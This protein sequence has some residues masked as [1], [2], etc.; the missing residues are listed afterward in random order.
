MWGKLKKEWDACN[1]GEMQSPID[2]SNERVR[3]IRKPEKRNYKLCNATVKNRGHDI[4]V[5]I[6]KLRCTFVQIDIEEI[7]SE[8]TLKTKNSV[9][10]FFLI[11]ENK[12]HRKPI[13]KHFK[14]VHLKG[15]LE[16]CI[17]MPVF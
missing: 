4:S 7:I 1:K 3:I 11:F 16:I 2:L 9:L 5:S 14:P 15:F 8:L 12:Y 17:L 10:N 6:S 13:R